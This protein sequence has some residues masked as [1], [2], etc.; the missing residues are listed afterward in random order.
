MAGLRDEDR[1]LFAN[2]TWT[3]LNELD[4]AR[5]VLFL[6]VGSTEAHGPHL[7]LQTD[8]LISIE[9]ALRAAGELDRRGTRAFV[10]PPLPYGVTYVGSPFPGTLG[11]SPGALSGVM[12]DLCLNLAEHGF[13]RLCLANSHLEPAHIEALTRGIREAQERVEIRVAFPD[14]RES[15]WA[16][17]L[18]E[19]FQKGSRH[20]GSYEASLVLAIRP[21]LVREARMRQLPPVWIDLP[22]RLREGARTFK[23]A[24]SDL[25]Y[26]GDPARASR[27]EGE[28]LLGA[29]TRML[30][31]AVDEQLG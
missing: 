13:R 20:A 10:L 31:T 24:G 8:L 1:L 2:Q 23:E 17:E 22:Q 27:E 21:E 6:P 12:R 15:R 9:T 16:Q 25:A 26:F 18:S 4:R 7:P 5:A 3:E 14:K 29:L 30:L 11:V 28:R 19:E